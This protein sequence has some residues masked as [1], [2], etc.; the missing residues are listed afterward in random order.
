[1]IKISKKKNKLFLFSL[2]FWL[3]TKVINQLRNL[4]SKHTYKI[5]GIY[6]FDEKIIVKPGKKKQT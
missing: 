4:R 2:D 1:M 3:L 5:Q 6:F